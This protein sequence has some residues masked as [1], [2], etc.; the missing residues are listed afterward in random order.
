M[1]VANHD[2]V[3]TPEG[4]EAIVKTAIDAF[5]RVDIVINN[6]GILRDKAFHNMTPDLVDPVIDVHLRGAFNVTRPAWIKMREQSYGRV[7]N[8]ASTAGHLRQLRPGQLRRGEDGPRR[9][10]PG[11]RRRGRQE[12]HQGQR[13][14]PDRPTRMT[15]DL[16]GPHGRAS[17]TPSSI[18][19]VV[20]WLAHEDCPVTG[21]IYSVGGGMVARFFIGLTTGIFDPELTLEGMRDQF[22]EIRDED[23]YMVPDGD[24]RRAP[25]AARPTSKASNRRARH[26][27][28]G[29]RG[30]ADGGAWTPPL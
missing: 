21:E 23:G 17:S 6:A 15:E 25:Q 16:L 20:A 14:R 5:G 13:H 24:R 27:P 7:V 19:P 12:Q 9:L 2:S 10:H 29:P 11:A 8:T 22:D 3:A 30:G 28:N 18:S 4:G 1:A 26:R